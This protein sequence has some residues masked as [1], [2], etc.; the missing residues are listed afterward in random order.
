MEKFKTGCTLSNEAQHNEGGSA[1][2]SNP[3]PVHSSI[4]GHTKKIEELCYS[5][6]QHW[7]SLRQPTV[8]GNMPSGF[9]RGADNAGVIV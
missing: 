4:T 1:L 9:M 2:S 7:F 3:F 6:Q 8:M 5:V